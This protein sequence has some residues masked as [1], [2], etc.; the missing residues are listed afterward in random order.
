[1]GQKKSR[2]V[3][4]DEDSYYCGQVINNKDQQHAEGRGKWEW[5]DSIYNGEFKS[6]RMNGKG[7]CIYDDGSY[8]DGQFKNNVKHGQ[9]IMYYQDG[10]KYI[11]NFENDLCHGKGKFIYESGDYYIGDFSI[12]NITGKG[13]MYDADNRLL[14]D[15]EWLFGTFHG[16]GKYYNQNNI[17]VYDG[18]WKE[19]VAHGRGK[20]YNNYGKL[21]FNGYFEE[22]ERNIEFLEK[23]KINNNKVIFDKKL[24]GKPKLDRVETINPFNNIEP[25]TPPLDNLPNMI[26]SPKN[27]TPLSPN[28]RLNKRS[29]PT[30]NN[31]MAESFK[32][33][34]KDEHISIKKLQNKKQKTSIINPKN[35]VP[36][37]YPDINKLKPIDKTVVKNNPMNNIL[38][39]NMKFRKSNLVINIPENNIT[40]EDINL[41]HGVKKLKPI[42]NGNNN[43]IV[44]F[45]KKEKHNFKN[46]TVINPLS[47]NINKQIKLNTL[48]VHSKLQELPEITSV[49]PPKLPSPKNSN[50][51]K[52]NKIIKKEFSQIPIC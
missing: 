50:I 43:K 48:M 5:G 33:E 47:D 32:I 37:L 10:C 9:G 29:S 44:N 39:N 7:V 41:K 46:N 45:F 36:N 17:I 21:L 3:A 26:I 18:L 30:R 49:L 34:Q 35:T 2:I 23:S 1:M 15:G 38:S 31:V 13:K 4:Y 28:I 25:S 51:F 6:N 16:Y 24:T 8:Y 27:N 42:P 20:Y 52:K 12:D 22:G 40:N 14:Y 19:G 11:G